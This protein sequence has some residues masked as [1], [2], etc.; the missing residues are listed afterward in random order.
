MLRKKLTMYLTEEHLILKRLT[1]FPEARDYKPQISYSNKISLR[2]REKL[3]NVDPNYTGN[4]VHNGQRKLLISEVQLLTNVYKDVFRKE[5]S[6]LCVYAGAYPCL[7]LT[8]LLHN[9]PNTYFLLVDPA[10]RDRDHLREWPSERVQLCSAFFNNDAA[11]AVV[12]WKKGLVGDEIH[13]CLN[14][15]DF[16]GEIYSDNIVFISDIRKEAE[17]DTMIATEMEEQKEWFNIL[18]A[19]AGLMKF[20]LPYVTPEFLN[21]ESHVYKYMEGIIYLPVWGRRSTT[22]CR[23]YVEQG[24]N[25]DDYFP[26]EI[27]RS[28]AGFNVTE[29]KKS[30]L[31][32]DVQYSTFD[33]AA[34]AVILSQFETTMG[35]KW[36]YHGGRYRAVKTMSHWGSSRPYDTR[37]HK[38]CRVSSVP[39]SLI[40]CSQCNFITDPCSLR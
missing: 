20:R 13:E 24:C 12:T 18:Q 33:E 15:L 25:D 37:H 32:G 27:E 19:K 5:T 39:I 11:T 31:V 26:K 6:V 34:E 8:Q 1:G 30:W 4:N 23:L 40:H 28:M 7:H 17:N 29:R 21:K 3:Q 16:P 35:R 10:F 38:R 9:F 2:E 22:E 14:R 36:N